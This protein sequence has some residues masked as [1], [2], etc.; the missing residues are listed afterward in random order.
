[1]NKL[2]NEVLH[3]IVGQ[4]SP[5]SPE[6]RNFTLTNKKHNENVKKHNELVVRDQLLHICGKL[7]RDNSWL[8]AITQKGGHAVLFGKALLS[9]L[10]G[11]MTS[12]IIMGLAVMGFKNREDSKLDNLYQDIPLR[13]TFLET[14][15]GEINKKTLHVKLDSLNVYLNI[16]NI[17]S[18]SV[19]ERDWFLSTNSSTATVIHLRGEQTR[20][21][22]VSHK[23]AGS[24]SF[25]ESS[26]LGNLTFDGGF[27]MN[28]FLR[29][30]LAEE[31]FEQEVTFEARD[32][33]LEELRKLECELGLQKT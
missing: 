26:N 4:L 25:L 5:L 21:V 9:L 15:R 27:S 32:E 24:L 31:V 13:K 29:L 22:E 12:P 8:D 23:V 20:L 28:G 2:P 30:G 14:L 10:H 3:N 18:G 33:V 16:D 1:M 17:L 7:F 19:W 11:N 6:I